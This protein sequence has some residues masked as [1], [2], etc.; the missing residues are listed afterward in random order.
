MNQIITEF[1]NQIVKS[2]SILGIIA[3]IFI[4]IYFLG[5]Y[6]YNNFIKIN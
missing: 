1:V 3:I 5:I 2:L 4:M 6:V